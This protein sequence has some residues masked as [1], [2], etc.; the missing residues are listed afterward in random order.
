MKAILS[1]PLVNIEGED[2]RVWRVSRDGR[3]FFVKT[4]YHFIKD[5]MVDNSDLRVPG[6]WPKLWSL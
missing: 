4:A 1:I 3:F 6:L 5:C 2:R